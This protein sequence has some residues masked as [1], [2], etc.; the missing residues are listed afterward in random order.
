MQG[1]EL[2]IYNTL[3]LQ[4]LRG[5]DDSTPR[6]GARVADGMWHHVAASLQTDTGVCDMTPSRACLEICTRV[7]WLVQMVVMGHTER[8]RARVCVCVCKCLSISVAVSVSAS[9]SISVSIS[10][11]VFVSV[12]VSM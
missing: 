2:E 3:D 6:V 12:T 7:T 9:V 8:A 10:V 1:R 11:S 4:I 5:N